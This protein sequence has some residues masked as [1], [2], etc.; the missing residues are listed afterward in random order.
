MIESVER[1]R[2]DNVPGTKRRKFATACLGLRGAI[3]MAVGVWH[4]LFVNESL[5]FWCDRMDIDISKGGKAKGVTSWVDVEND[6]P[7]EMARR[8]TSLSGVCLVVWGLFCI[9]AVF[10]LD[11]PAKKFISGCNIGAPISILLMACRDGSAVALL[12]PFLPVIALDILATVFAEAGPKLIRVNSN[13]NL[14]MGVPGARTGST[15]IKRINSHTELHTT[16]DD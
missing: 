7:A 1:L 3:T 15:T 16:K 6:A 5:D 12:L 13:S 11:A 8:L 9:Y 4:V 2:G 10:E 14:H